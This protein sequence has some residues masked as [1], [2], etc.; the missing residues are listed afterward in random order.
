MTFAAYASACGAGRPDTLWLALALPPVLVNAITG[1]AGFLTAALFV[2]G[3]ALLPK[4]PFAGGLLLGL[5]VVKP[6]L[7]LVL[8]FALLAGRRMA[9]DRRRRPPPRSGSLLLGLLAVRLG[10]HA[11]LARQCRPVRLGRQRGAGRLAPHGERLSARCASP[12]SAPAPAWIAHGLVALAA[13]AAACWLWHRRRDWGAR[14]RRARRRDRAREPLSVRLRHA[15]PGRALRLAGRARPPPAC[16]LALCWAVLL[17]G[18]LQVAGL[19]RRAEPGAARRR[20]SC[21]P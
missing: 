1:Q 7:G 14:S 19:E 5:L 8:P 2:G 10:D 9:R 12:A 21:S 4:R 15:D 13:V 20:S 18:L 17:L 11:G 16:S 3:M 6:Q